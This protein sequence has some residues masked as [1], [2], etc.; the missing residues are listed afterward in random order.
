MKRALLSFLAAAAIAGCSS[1]TQS[2]PA[3]EA[4]PRA[5]MKIAFDITDGNPH[6]VLAQLGIIDVTRKQLLAS[7]VTPRFVLTFRGGASYFT[8]TDV[9][10]IKPADRADAA[11]IAA[12]LREL[13]QANGIVALEQC[14]LPLAHRK[15]K[16]A[17]VMPEVKVV[18]NGWI[19]LASYQHMGYA[20]IVP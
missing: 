9:S 15:L 4:A 7:G 6:A 13:R 19:S 2:S 17:D 5:E 20:Y 3:A 14:N 18:P 11:R 1:L 8:Q 12:K 10:K 16:A